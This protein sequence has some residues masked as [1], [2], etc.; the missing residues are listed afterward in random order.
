MV[1]FKIR[2]VL[3]WVILVESSQME[4]CNNFIL[5]RFF[6]SQQFFCNPG[7]CASRLII[8]AYYRWYNSPRLYHPCNAQC[9]SDCVDHA[10]QFYYILF[11][12]DILLAV[13]DDPGGGI[14]SPP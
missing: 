9:I 7:S 14:N 3:N 5:G 8:Q 2:E 1:E 10:I 6:K 13:V 12:L 11:G 4:E